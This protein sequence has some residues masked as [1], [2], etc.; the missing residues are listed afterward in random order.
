ME[1]VDATDHA[2][3]VVLEVMRT[4]PVD[5]IRRMIS[6]AVGR[7]KTRTT[8]SSSPFRLD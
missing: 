8:V 3:S 7:T 4:K 6:S 5:A 1:G 2:D